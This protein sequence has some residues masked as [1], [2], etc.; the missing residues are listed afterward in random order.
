MFIDGIDSFAESTVVHRIWR[1]TSTADRP[2]LVMPAFDRGVDG[3][4]LPGRDDQPN[5][6]IRTGDD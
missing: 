4:A 2:T 1:D 5:P 6:L 3:T